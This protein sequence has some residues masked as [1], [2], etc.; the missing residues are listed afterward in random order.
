MHDQIF[1]GV[2][3]VEYGNYI[4]APYCGKLLGD[5]GA[6]VI[7]VE[8]PFGGDES[9]HHGPFP[10]DI[11]HIERSGLFLYLCA[12]KLSVTLDI[13]KP[14]GKEILL[15]L[16]GDADVL[17]DNYPVQYM[18]DL[19][20]DY[21]TLKKPFPGLIAASVSGFGCSGPYKDYKSYNINAC[22]AGAASVAVGSSDREPISPPFG[23]SEYV[24][25]VV[26]AIGI[27]SALLAREK[28]GFGQA[29]DI[30]TAEC[31]GYT[32][33]MIDPNYTLYGIPWKRS[34]HRASESGGFY[35]G[36][37]LPCKDGFIA[38]WVRSGHPWKRFIEVMGN[39]EWS[40][41]PRYANRAIMGR[42]YPGEVDALLKPWLM[43]HTT[44]EIMQICVERAIPFSEVM[45][46][47]EV[48][49]CPHLNEREFFL[50]IERE[51]VGK[52]KYPG[53]PFNFSE[54]PCRINRP[55]PLLGQHNEK[56]YKERLGY[57]SEELVRLFRA[58]VI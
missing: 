2:K 38:M 53:F 41:N 12:N 4:S 15:R 46:I 58:R 54:T 1:S 31:M 28:T 56:I 49:D 9:R 50:E 24:G 14:S 42:E 44:D 23:Q 8:Q 19:G 6:E 16:L 55:A 18:K 33:A 35:P 17:V 45:S 34:G 29:V 52:L 7:K 40:K 20:L 5:L 51:Q 48:A 32:A 13:E 47:K 37:I 27:I 25:G 36:T 22:A 3:V 39:P 30:S 10:N 21:E 57:S 26:A 11:P 43:A